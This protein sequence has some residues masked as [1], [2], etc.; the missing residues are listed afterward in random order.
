MAPALWIVNFALLVHSEPPD[1]REDARLLDADPRESGVGDR[2]KPHRA[3]VVQRLRIAVPQLTLGRRGLRRSP[4][5]PKPALGSPAPSVTAAPSAES[6]WSQLPIACRARA[7]RVVAVRA[8]HWLG[9]I[10]STSTNP[11]PKIPAAHQNAVVSPWTCAADARTSHVEVRRDVAGDGAGVDRRE[12]RSADRAANLLGRVDHGRRDARFVWR[13]A[14]CRGRERRGEED[15]AHRDTDDEQAWQ[16]AGAEARG[17]RQLGEQKHPDNP[18]RHAEE[19]QRF[20][21]GAL[22]DAGLDGRRG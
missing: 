7:V 18:K 6:S 14:E 21:A 20:D 19:H 8:S 11:R 15:A 2:R 4:T 16:D 12:Q 17:G 22:D 3:S 13:H 5:A 1:G 10:S 9:M